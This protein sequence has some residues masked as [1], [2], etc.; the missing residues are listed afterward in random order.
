MSKVTEWICSRDNPT[1]PLKQEFGGAC[2]RSIQNH[3]C[4]RPLSSIP[5]A[6]KVDPQGAMA[7][8]FVARRLAEGAFQVRIQLHEQ[9]FTASLAG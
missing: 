5:G 4:P 3:H 9:V 8:L 6:S 1:C 2:R 7:R